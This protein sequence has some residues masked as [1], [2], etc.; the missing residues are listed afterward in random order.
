M[1]ERYGAVDYTGAMSQRPRRRSWRFDLPPHEALEG[2]SQRDRL[3]VVERLNVYL[4]QHPAVRTMKIVVMLLSMSAGIF[5]NWPLSAWFQSLGMGRIIAHMIGAGLMA[6]SVAIV[7][8]VLGHWLLWSIW[9]RSFRRA[10]RE[11]G[12]DVCVEC[13]Y[14]LRGLDNHVTRCPECGAGRT[15]PVRSNR[16]S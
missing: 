11:I 2:L 4:K 16:P 9:S 1:P 15:Q 13:G 14:W 10:L 6:L 5:L 7:S 12:R 8:I 3:D